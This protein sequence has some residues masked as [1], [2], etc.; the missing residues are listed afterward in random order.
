MKSITLILLLTCVTIH[1]LV[2]QHY[3]TKPYLLIE[4][5]QSG[6]QYKIKPESQILLKT[7]NDSIVLKVWFMDFASDSSIYIY[8]RKEIQLSEIEY[9]GITPVH[10]KRTTNQVLLVT[11]T[12]I[13]ATACIGVSNVTHPNSAFWLPWALFTLPI[14]YIATPIV[15]SIVY[16]LTPWH[17]FQRGKH[18]TIKIVKP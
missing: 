16:R 18:L 17:S 15:S 4:N 2:A 3:W 9:I 8:N 14:T 10:W 12:I 7:M 6:K 1:P 5:A 13:F 11:G